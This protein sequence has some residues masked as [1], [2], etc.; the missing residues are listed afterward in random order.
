MQVSGGV[1]PDLMDVNGPGGAGK[2]SGFVKTKIEEREK[3]LQDK[4]EEAKKVL[5]VS[6]LFYT[7]D[8]CFFTQPFFVHSREGG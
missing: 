6:V 4:Q 7:L 2:K 5:K 8:V 3:E 1:A